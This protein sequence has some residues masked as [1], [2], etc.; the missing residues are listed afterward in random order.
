MRMGL[1]RSRAPRLFQSGVDWYSL[2]RAVLT[3]LSVQSLRKILC[4]YS[5]KCGRTHSRQF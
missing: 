1:F 3:G 5:L 2:F 4:V